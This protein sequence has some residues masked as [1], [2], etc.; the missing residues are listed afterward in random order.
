MNV[1]K[2]VDA[3]KL[4]DLHGR[5]PRHLAQVVSHEVRDHHV[6]SALL[7]VGPQGLRN[8]GIAHRVGVTRGR[9]LDRLADE[10]IPL[11][12]E[13]PF[14]AGAKDVDPVPMEPGGERGGGLGGEPLEGPVRAPPVREGAVD[15]PTKDELLKVD[16]QDVPVDAPYGVTLMLGVEA[17]QPR[18][19]ALPSP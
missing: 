12:A 3:A 7:G 17:T 10:P 11:A 16:L 5:G 8:G 1:A 18:N 15:F 9:S 19:R 6:L 2:A 14:G 4:L 13:E